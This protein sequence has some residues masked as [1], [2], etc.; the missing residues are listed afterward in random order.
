MTSHYGHV[1]VQ[2]VIQGIRDKIRQTA[3]EV[4]FMALNRCQCVVDG[5]LVQW[6]RI[7]QEFKTRFRTLS[8]WDFIRVNLLWRRKKK[9]TREIDR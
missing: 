9:A 8:A 1:L 4:Y 6:S 2:S 7:L 3:M 5:I